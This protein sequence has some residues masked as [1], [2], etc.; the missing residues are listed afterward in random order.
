MIDLGMARPG[1]AWRGEA[2]HGTARV[3]N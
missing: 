3:F 1:T 2:G